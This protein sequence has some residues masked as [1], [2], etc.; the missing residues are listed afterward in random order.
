MKYIDH[1]AEPEAI[2]LARALINL[3]YKWS[4]V[5]VVP[6]CGEREHFSRLIASVNSSVVGMDSRV[7]VVVVVNEN[8][9]TLP[10]LSA[11]NRQL[12]TEWRRKLLG[13]R[14]FLNGFAFLGSG[15]KGLDILFLDYTKE[16]RKF[17]S[18]QGVGL[19]RKIGCDLSLSLISSGFI[20]SSWIRTTDA[21]ARLPVDYF[22]R[23]FKVKN[24]VS[25]LIFPFEHC[26]DAFAEPKVIRAAALYDQY[27]RYLESGLRYARSPYA[28]QTVG[29]TIAVDYEAYAKVRGFPKRL[30]G[31]D[32]YF[33]NKLAKVG[34]VAEALGCPIILSA[35]ISARVPFGTGVGIS[36]ICRA[37]D[38]GDEY[39]V[40]HPDAFIVLDILLRS[41]A[42]TAVMFFK[43]SSELGF[44]IL[45]QT[46]ITSKL[47]SVCALK[48]QTIAFLDLLGPNYKRQ[49]LRVADCSRDSKSLLKH[50]H[51]W[52][53][54]FRTQK[55][56]RGL[57]DR[58]FGMIPLQS[59]RS[60]LLKD[61]PLFDR[62]FSNL[63]ADSPH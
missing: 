29:S 30:A 18:T 37:I 5:L 20:K 32:F 53:D 21:D 6:S 41:V 60:T 57:C 40:Y 14:N 46:E 48:Q 33:L 31:E 4:E 55:F 26:P 63:R 50:F 13:M 7:L 58:Y 27:L 1:Y 8:S 9:T 15:G 56:L 59:L 36:K 35:R 38:G 3:K 12:L 24:G 25:G 61:R 2:S 11:K 23:Q 34:S 45:L 51:I 44:D 17:P 16:S 28:F 62:A 54:G 49:L 22:T 42:Q 52:F 43:H 10:A 39:C 19:A 47:R